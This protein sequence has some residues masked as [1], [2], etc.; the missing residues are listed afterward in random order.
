MLIGNTEQPEM[1]VLNFFRFF[2]VLLFTFGLPAWAEEN[3]YRGYLQPLLA[4]KMNL[5]LAIVVQATIFSLAHLGYSSHTFD[6]GSAFVT[7]LILGWLRG[8]D[9][10]LVSPFISHGLFWMM[11]AFMVIPQ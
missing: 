4:N 10:S 3:L 5:R 1:F 7:G 9:S 8:R 6:F 2:I 11:G